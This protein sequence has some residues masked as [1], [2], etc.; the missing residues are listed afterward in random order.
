MKQWHHGVD[1]EVRIP[2]GRPQPVDHRATAVDRPHIPDLGKSAPFR[3]HPDLEV[4]TEVQEIFIPS[5]D[6][7]LTAQ[8]SSRGHSLVR[9]AA[10]ALAMASVLFPW[11]AWLLVS[12]AAVYLLG[13][14]RRRGLPP[15]PR[16]LPIIGNLHLLGNQP[17]YSMLCTIYF[18]VF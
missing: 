5:Q 3:H 17:N 16:P 10:V 11:L 2:P 9:Y 8:F 7:R 18:F 15:G 12:L 13:H 4:Q 6:R 14:G 1:L